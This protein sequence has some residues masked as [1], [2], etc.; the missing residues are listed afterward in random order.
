MADE[1]RQAIEALL[2]VIEEPIDVEAL[3][4]IVELPADDVEDLLVDLAAELERDRRGVVLRRVAGGWRAYTAPAAYAYVERYV[5]AGRRGRLSHAALETLAVVAYKQPVSRQE[6][7]DIRGVAAD[8]AVR[9]LVTRGYVE[10]AGRSD[11]PGH[12]VLYRTTTRLL[13]EL[14]LDTL[15]ELPALAE[16][17]EDGPAP[18]EPASGDFRGARA[19]LAAAADRIRQAAETDTSGAVDDAAPRDR[20]GVDEALGQLSAAVDRA[21]QAAGASLERAAAEAPEGDGSEGRPGE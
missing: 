12:A 2:F 13:E 15:D 5:L 9:S 17:L 8:A 1:A 20:R 19:R 3:A 11:G 18:D 4:E 21:A 7:G 14:G 10:E 16:Y 6:I